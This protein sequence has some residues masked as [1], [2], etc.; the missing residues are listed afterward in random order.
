MGGIPLSRRFGIFILVAVIAGLNVS[1]NAEDIRLNDGRI[2]IDAKIISETPDSVTIRYA[3]GLMMAQKTSLPAKTLAQH[4]LDPKIA[5]AAQQQAIELS[6]AKE[7]A[8]KGSASAELKIGDIY[9]NGVGVAT[10]HGEA[11]RW[12]LKAASQGNSD[13]EFNVGRMYYDGDGDFKNYPKA[14]KWYLEAAGQN[15]AAAQFN[16]GMMY[17]NGFGID[18]DSSQAAEWYLKAA[19][20]GMVA[21][22]VNLGVMY[23]NGEGVPRDQVEGLAWTYIAAASGDERS[24]RNRDLMEDDLGHDM[25]LTAQHRSKEILDEMETEEQQREQAALA[26]KRS[27]PEGSPVDDAVTATGS[28]AI[29]SA[30][31][32]VLTAAHVIAGATRVRISTALGIRDCKILQVDTA[33]DIAVLKLD[34][35]PYL[36]L[37]IASRGIRLGQNVSTIGFPETDLQGFSPK[38]TKGEISSINGYQ[39]DPCEWQISVPVQMGNSGGPLLDESGNLVGI[40]ASKLGLTAAENTGDLIENVNYAVKASYAMP[41]LEPYLPGTFSEAKASLAPPRFEDM[42][43]KAQQSVVL[44]LVY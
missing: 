37:P 19:M 4:P 20:Q 12:Y 10:D 38:V 24:V 43:A 13:A 15:V 3:G 7:A 30:D 5:A 16:V 6:K 18:Q 34:G 32:L 23:S 9:F 28:G 22:E 44:I 21:A 42:V 2:L 27:R 25:A 35:G 1:L 36:A 17:D 26:R 39:D 11:L 31:G 14:M 40:V 33:N 29:V 8:E 41:L